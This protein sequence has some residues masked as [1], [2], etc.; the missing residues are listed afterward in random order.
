MSESLTNAEADTITGANRIT[1]KSKFAELIPAGLIEAHRS[2][3]GVF[4][5]T[6]HRINPPS[7]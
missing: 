5:V 6:K 1:L 7:L 3:G 4:Y 2:G